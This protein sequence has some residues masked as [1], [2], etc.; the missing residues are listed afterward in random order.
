MGKHIDHDDILSAATELED[1]YRKLTVVL[2]EG[3]TAYAPGSTKKVFT[4]PGEIIYYIH[5]TGWVAH[6]SIT[7]GTKYIS[8]GN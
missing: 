6:P 3:D 7:I 8:K 5:P 2:E 4:G 1:N